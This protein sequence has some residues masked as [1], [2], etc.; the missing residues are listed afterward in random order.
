MIGHPE[1]AQMIPHAGRM[2]LI[3]VVESW[4]A[5]HIR[6]STE[7]H[8]MADH[9]LASAGIL[10]VLAGLEYGAQAMALHGR[11]SAS[12]GERPR[13]GVIASVREIVWSVARLD[14]IATP[15]IID[16]EKLAGDGASAL[17]AFGVSSDD[18]LLI[19]GRASVLL[20]VEAP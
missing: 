13:A 18:R 11:L 4:S 2:C 9:P 6:C 15:L 3:D 17:Y 20:A 16:A 7:S 10:P 5:S 1:I 14:D 12:V 8:R 19:N